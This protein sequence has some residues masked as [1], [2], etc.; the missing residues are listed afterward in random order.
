MDEENFW[1]IVQHAN[2]I[3]DGNMDRKCGALRQQISVLPEGAALEFARRFDAMMDM[4]ALG[5][6]IRHQRRVR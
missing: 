1:E 2:D 3:S 5:N 6:C 4:A